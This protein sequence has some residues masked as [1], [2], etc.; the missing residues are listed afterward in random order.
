MP[1]SFIQMAPDST[2]K[3]ARSRQRVIGAN[4]IEESYVITVS[5]RVKSGVYVVNTGAHVIAAAAHA[6]TVG[7]WWLL[8]PVGSAVLV[9]LRRVE[10]ASQLGSVLATPTSPRI[11]IERV[12]FTGTHSGA[13]ITVADADS[14]APTP[15][16]RLSLASTGATLAA[17]AVAFAF[18]PIASATAVGYTAAAVMDWTPDEDGQLVLAAGEGIVCRQPDAGTTADTRRFVTNIAY[19]EYTIP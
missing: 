17:G 15:T 6:A 16:S 9:S 10:F 11:T 14:V 2:G 13:L 12:T 3:K 8:N 18:L 4:T 1:E 19:D 7:F 5:A